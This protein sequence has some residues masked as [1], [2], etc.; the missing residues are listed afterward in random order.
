MIVAGLYRSVRR[1]PAL[2]GMALVIIALVLGIVTIVRRIYNTDLD[3][4]EM[5]PKLSGRE[6]VAHLQEPPGHRNSALTQLFS[7]Y[8]VVQAIILLESY[9][10]ENPPFHQGPSRPS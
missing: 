9:H 7:Q 8:R 2:F 4:A 3:A 10:G 5:I 6:D 1:Y